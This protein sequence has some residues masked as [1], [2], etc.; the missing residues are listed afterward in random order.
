MICVQKTVAIRIV[1]NVSLLRMFFFMSEKYT[2]LPLNKKDLGKWPQDL[3]IRPLRLPWH[4]REYLNCR[5]FRGRYLFGPSSPSHSVPFRSQ[6]NEVYMEVPWLEKDLWSTL[7]NLKT[8]GQA[9]GPTPRRVTRFS[10]LCRW[11]H[12]SKSAISWPSGP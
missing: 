4:L 2:Q 5:F 9:P 11:D 1:I 8:P 7:I 10:S 3:I 12:P 6:K